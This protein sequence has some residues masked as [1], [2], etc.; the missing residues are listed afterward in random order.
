MLYYAYGPYYAKNLFF[1]LFKSI[2]RAMDKYP[3]ETP[4]V[5]SRIKKA[6]RDIVSK[7]LP[8]ARGD[9]VFCGVRQET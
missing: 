9:N 2:E 8:T 3:A 7:I 6:S 4:I 5:I 1:M